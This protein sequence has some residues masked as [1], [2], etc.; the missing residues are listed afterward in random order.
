MENIL[1]GLDLPTHPGLMVGI[2][3][4]DDAGVF[5][6]NDDMALIQTMDFFTPM[7]DD[8]YIFGQIAA[9]NAINDIYAMG[10]TPLTAM[11]LVCFPQC[12]DMQVLRR[13]LEGGISKIK[14]AGVVLVGGHTVDDN[15]PKYG[16]SVTGLIK[17]D[18]MVTNCNARPGDV[19]ILTKPLGT[20]VIATAIKA[21]MASEPSQQEAVKW[22]STLNRESCAAMME[23]GVNSATD[24]TGFGLVG[25]LYEMAS[26]S[27]VLIELHTDK[28]PLIEETREYAGM[29]LIPAGA[30]TNRDYLGDKVDIAP[31]VDATLADLIFSPETAGGLL[32]AVEASREELLVNKLKSRGSMAW[33]IGRVVEKG[34]KPLIVI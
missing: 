7:V 32:I 16:L 23:T 31:D 30:Y 14:E 11:N 8:P 12:G 20:G 4:R 19:L 29:G 13:I 9:V 3:T 6:L 10:G 22:M 17:P 5:K 28:I 33:T 2:E 18:L 26:A 24:V 1:K 34:F 25:H 21:G 27:D 15:E